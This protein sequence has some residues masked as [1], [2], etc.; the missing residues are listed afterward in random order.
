MARIAEEWFAICG[1]CEVTI[2]DIGEPLLDLLPQL[3]FVHM[4]VLMDHKYYGQTGEKDKI[5][6]P[7]ADIGLISGGV[8]NE[9][10]KE[11]AQ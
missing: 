10:H 3:E 5:E 7:E 6:I 8:R 9:E 1:G 11:I 2:L 4:P